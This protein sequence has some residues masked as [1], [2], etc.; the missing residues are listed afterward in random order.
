MKAV[1]F[2][3]DGLMF[4]TERVY[5]IA[6][7]YAGEKI[8]IGKAG[9]MTIKTL[10]MNSAMTRDV[11]HEEFGDTYDEDALL[12]YTKE[13]LENYYKDQRVPVKKGLY[14]LISFL[15]EKGY[16]L[17]VASSSATWEV[18]KH[19]KDADVMDDFKVIVC[20]DMIDKS[21]PEPDIYL[22]ACELLGE[23]P[24]NCYALEDSENGLL[25][26]YRAGCIPIMIPDLWQPDEGIMTVVYKKFCDLDEVKEFLEK[27]K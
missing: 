19:L 21:K 14:S 2:D 7:D 20:G 13:F 22:K 18:E 24:E 4:D 8:G 26:A 5:V 9:Y 25:S 27:E 16:K 23:K 6:C 11:W 17:A 10:G 15:K 3:M 1:I 12:K